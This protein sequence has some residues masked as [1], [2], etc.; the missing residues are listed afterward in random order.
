MQKIALSLCFFVALVIASLAAPALTVDDVIAK[1]VAQQGLV[2][3]FSADIVISK[4]TEEAKDA[5]AIKGKIWS[6]GFER[7]KIIFDKSDPHIL[8][9]NGEKLLVI[10]A[11]GKKSVLEIAPEEKFDVGMHNQGRLDFGRLSQFFSIKLVPIKLDGKIKLSCLPKADNIINDRA[12]FL[13]DTNKWVPI[14]LQTYDN[15]GKLLTNVEMNYEQIDRISV[16][17]SIV[18]NSIFPTAKAVTKIEFTNVKINRGINESEFE[19]N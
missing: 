15:K 2:K 11:M 6:R 18:I 14:N 16:P 12:D 5:P 1:L 3:D 13:I 8:I 17:V 4:K 10:D 9:A 7:V 19:L